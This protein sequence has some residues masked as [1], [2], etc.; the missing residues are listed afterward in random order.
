[1]AERK[2][3]SYI[4]E[5]IIIIWTRVLGTQKGKIIHGYRFYL[6]SSIWNESHVDK[7]ITLRGKVCNRVTDH[8]NVRE[9]KSCDNHN[10]LA[11]M[12]LAERSRN[13]RR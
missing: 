10:T 2:Q 4:L 11:D 13:G 6:E 1:M 9:T 12:W 8:S 5:T 7:T 3:I